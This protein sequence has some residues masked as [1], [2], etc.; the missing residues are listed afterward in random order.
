MPAAP[1]FWRTASQALCR[2]YCKDSLSYRAWKRRSGSRCAAWY[3]FAWSAVV[4]SR[5]G[6]VAGTLTER[7]SLR[8]LVRLP[9]L[10]SGGVLLSPALL[11][12]LCPAPTPSRLAC[13]L[14]EEGLSSSPQDCP[15]IPRPLR[16]GVLDGCASQGFPAS[17]A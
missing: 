1:R 6:L 17:V 16:R 14:A 3:S 8:C 4:L 11:A 5:D 9:G 7:P 12:V 15:C 10:P 13:A 2:T